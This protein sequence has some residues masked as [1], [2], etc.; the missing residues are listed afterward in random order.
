MIIQFNQN[1]LLNTS[2]EIDFTILKNDL[3]LFF[4]D[5]VSFS[6]TY[7]NSIDCSFFNALNEEEIIQANNIFINHLYDEII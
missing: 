1:N 6:Y 2:K 7:L 4:S 5:N 3:D